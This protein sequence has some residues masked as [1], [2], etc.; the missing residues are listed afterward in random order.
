M[1]DYI[2]I[3]KKDLL[4]V[5][6]NLIKNNIVNQDF[7]KDN[8][9]I[10]YLSKSKQG[11]V[12]TN[13]FIL[14]NSQLNKNDYDLR[15][16]IHKNII[17]FEYVKKIE[18]TKVG[19]I[20]IFF[21]ENFLIKKLYLVLSNPNNY[22]NNVSGNNDKV[23]IEFVSA[24]PT[25]PLHIAHIRGAVL[26]DVLASILQATGHKV[27]REYYLNDAGSQINILGNSLYK[28]Y[29]QIFGI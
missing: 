10:D 2:S 8:L 27:T 3:L 12:S 4:D 21:E 22:G 5:I 28:R 11:E 14:L 1:N 7:K 20:N 6:D 9:T 19:F 29:Q 16:N 26:G 17:N 25:G 23:N 18:I 15:K 24:N 13:L